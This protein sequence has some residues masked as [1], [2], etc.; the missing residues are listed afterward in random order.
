MTQFFTADYAWLWALGLALALFFPVRQLIWALSVKRAEQKAT[1]DE[2]QRR[3]LHRRASF[4]AALLCL[5][6][7]VLYTSYLFGSS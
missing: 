5:V 2:A 3:A 1:T 7:A 4:T 6:F